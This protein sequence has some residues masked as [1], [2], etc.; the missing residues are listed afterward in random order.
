M[1]VLALSYGDTRRRLRQVL[2]DRFKEVKHLL[3][4]LVVVVGSGFVGAF[5]R[6]A[7]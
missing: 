4:L 1:S 3:L 2:Q 5:W 6:V 7:D